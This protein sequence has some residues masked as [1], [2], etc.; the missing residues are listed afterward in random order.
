MVTDELKELGLEIDIPAVVIRGE[1]SEMRGSVFAHFLL[2]GP[3]GINDRLLRSFQ[4]EQLFI[5]PEARWD[6]DDRIG[7][8]RL[9][10]QAEFV[11]AYKFVE[12]PLSNRISFNWE[13]AIA[14]DG[15][16]IL[17]LRVTY[18]RPDSIN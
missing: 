18:T 1:S 3:V 16:E 2:K 7:W 17:R 11:T 10:E 5:G 9:P 15:D 4:E 6:I 12:G 13:Q 8:W 14:E